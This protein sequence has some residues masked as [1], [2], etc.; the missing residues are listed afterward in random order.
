VITIFQQQQRAL[1]ESN[2]LFRQENKLAESIISGIIDE[3][4]SRSENSREKESSSTSSEPGD[5][6]NS[7][8]IK[9]VAR[10]D[11]NSE[12]IS[13][14]ENSDRKIV[15]RRPDTDNTLTALRKKP[16]VSARI[17]AEKKSF[18]SSRDSQSV[19]KVT[20]FSKTKK[21]N[22]ILAKQ[23]P[24]VDP[25]V[26]LNE[27]TVKQ[28]P[29]IRDPKVSFNEASV[30]QPPPI[31][32]PKVSLNEAAVKQPPPIKDPKV[33]LN[34]APVKQ[35][36]PIK[37]LKVSLN[38]MAVKQPP[39]VFV[40]SKVLPNELKISKQRSEQDASKPVDQQPLI[41]SND[42]K[43]VLKSMKASK[44]LTS[45]RSNATREK[46][47]TKTT[48]APKKSSIQS[49]SQ[50]IVTRKTLDGQQH[51]NAETSGT[52]KET[53]I[54]GPQKLSIQNQPVFLEALT[55]NERITRPSKH[56]QSSYEEE[57]FKE[58]TT[59]NDSLNQL[60]NVH[61]F[62]EEQKHTFSQSDLINP[63]VQSTGAMNIGNLQNTNEDSASLDIELSDKETLD[64]ETVAEHQELNITLPGVYTDDTENEEDDMSVR[65]T[66]ANQSHL[67]LVGEATKTTI[68]T[69][70]DKLDPILFKQT[71]P[72]IKD[73]QL[74]SDEKEIRQPSPVS[75]LST[76]IKSQQAD[77]L[78]QSPIENDRNSR[79]MA[80]ESENFNA[81]CDFEVTSEVLEDKI[82]RNNFSP[83]LFSISKSVP[84]SP[85]RKELSFP[86]CCSDALNP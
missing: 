14:E 17:E 68:L 44:D 58:V 4:R 54:Q 24:S 86:L 65:E 74:P 15:L 63:T 66:S 84:E 76:L 45:S 43:S 60:H 51:T 2:N 20:A 18:R 27:I 61:L 41:A 10:T 34:E 80:V 8:N 83:L 16:V 19:S 6:I 32:D 23:A 49:P 7:E 30:K 56:H 36:P 11:T 47:A 39:E 40:D 55:K 77:K 1:D 52:A 28:P 59:E 73:P 70:R 33:S 42:P 82:R 37:D 22:E 64:K 31:K 38:E 29:P 21:V 3:I 72:T 71:I 25:K 79:F 12:L 62:S 69:K 57:A 50:S 85:D 67:N 78:M 26:S 35:P 53:K 9:V 81:P 48:S 5:R 75:D 46:I 13:F